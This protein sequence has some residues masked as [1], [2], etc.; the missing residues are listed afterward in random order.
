[1]NPGDWKKDEA[2][3]R[4]LVEMKYVR[5]VDGK[6][7]TCMNEDGTTGTYLF[8]YEAWVARGALK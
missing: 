6:I 5:L 4:A 2:F 8:M 7:V 1:M 3:V